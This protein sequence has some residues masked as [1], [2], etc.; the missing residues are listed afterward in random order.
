MHSKE[1]EDEDDDD[2]MPF[3]CVVGPQRSHIHT[4]T[5]IQNLLY[6]LGKMALT[7]KPELMS[8]APFAVTHWSALTKKQTRRALSAVPVIKI[9]IPRGKKPAGKSK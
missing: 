6:H 4:H 5:L 8:L 2:L 1:G 9:R 7:G 3:S